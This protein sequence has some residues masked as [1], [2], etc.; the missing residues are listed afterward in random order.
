M[1]QQILHR[2]PAIVRMQ[3]LLAIACVAVTMATKA[4][5]AQKAFVV[6]NSNY[7]HTPQLRNPVNDAKDLKVRLEALGYEASLGL[8]LKRTEF[9][10]KFQSFTQS[11]RSEDL[12]LIFY[13]GHAVQ[14][15]GENFLFPVDARV[16]KEEDARS[17]LVS[18]NALLSD[19]SRVSRSR[20]II[21][22]AC[23]NNPFAN[24]LE[25]TKS[26]RSAG[27]SRGLAR[28]Y[29]GIGTFIAYSTEPGNV[30]DDGDG[31]NSPF[32][33]SLLRH[34]NQSGADV[35]AVMRR[36]RSDVQRST[37]ERQI[38]WE[39]SSLIDEVTFAGTQPAVVAAA[40]PPAAK[41]PPPPTALPPPERIAEPYHYVSGL[42]PKGDN[43]LALRSGAGSDGARIATMGP[44]TLLKV[45]E[46]QGVW[47][48]VVL[49]D[50]TSGWAHGNW[51][52]CCRNFLST[53]RAISPAPTP[54]TAQPPAETCDSI[55]TSRNS[56][57]HRH[58]Y[59]FTTAR[60][61]QAFGNAGCFRDEGSARA[62]MS[63]ADQER[64]AALA[65]RERDLGCR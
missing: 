35:H 1:R 14:I 60:G 19:V 61:R 11:L 25:R 64:V 26:T 10:T 42:D 55:W 21:L 13:A 29:A 15:S 18:L 37:N 46:S 40:S 57:W 23:R 7:A 3:L 24:E 8:D 30:A 39:N 56:I 53:R 59:C 62:A 6:G 65:A 2:I 34:I 27:A 43:F 17:N 36:V 31:R 58:G 63:A 48:R 49:L 33:E 45:V 16:E 5:A 54:V 32:T 50:G 51:I 22:D 9:L 52:A 44:D 28:V 12:A 47:K 4:H 41:Q 20:I 38:P